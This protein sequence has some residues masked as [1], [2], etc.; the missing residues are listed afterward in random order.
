MP[1]VKG[2]GGRW[3]GTFSTVTVHQMIRITT[4]TVVMIMIW[5]AFWLDSWMP[6]VFFRQK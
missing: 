1:G 6:C 2:L 5:T 4:M 3:T